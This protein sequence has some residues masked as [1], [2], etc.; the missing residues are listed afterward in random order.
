VPGWHEA[1]AEA[2][3]RGEVN[4]VG[5][6]QEQHPDRCRLFMQWRRME[7]PIMVDALNLLGVSAVPITLFLDEHGIVRA[8]QPSLED[9]QDFLKA[10]FDPP[11]DPLEEARLEPLERLRERAKI[12]QPEDLRAYADSLVLW[13]GDSSLD[14]AIE[15]YRGA[16]ERAH[17]HAPTRFRLGV[18][19]RMRHDSDRRRTGDFQQA[20]S[21]WRQALD[22]DPNQYIWRRRIQQYGPR[23]DKPYPFY[24]W[25]GTARAEIIERG[26]EPA[27]LAVEPTGAEL[28][29]PAGAF[30]AQNGPI[31]E[32]DPG[33]RILRD[34]EGFIRIETVVVEDTE[35]SGKS[36]RLHLVFEPNAARKAHWN[37]EVDDLIVWLNPPQG[38]EADSRMQRVSIPPEPVSQEVRRVEFELRKDGSV[39]GPATASLYALYFVCED[40]NGACLYRRQDVEVPLE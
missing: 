18:A 34:E 16:L 15:A 37:N 14:A 25:V 35:S 7:W 24:D 13:G 19:H 36:L 38:W 33:G 6:I 17:S 4:V 1:T 22:L 11:S 39:E 30:E 9:F 5:I 29:H 20:V 27:P 31:Q 21:H 10:R 8:I 40:V 2:L 26:E 3:S 32:P 28:A 23:L 12:G